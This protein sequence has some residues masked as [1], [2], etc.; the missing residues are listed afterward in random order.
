MKTI[1]PILLTFLVLI[2][3]TTF[4]QNK[5]V[6]AN[7]NI[8]TTT[9]TVSDFDKIAVSGSFDVTLKKGKGKA[10]TIEASS[11]LMDIIETIVE[12]NQLKIKF[13]S[14]WNIRTSKKINIT[15]TYEALSAVTLSGSGSIISED[16]I[17]ANNLALKVSGS[18]NMKLKLFTDN[19]TA[20]ISGSGNLKLTGETNIVTCS[21]SGSGNLN[22]SNL[23]AAITN[24]K[25][26]GSGNVKIQASEEIYAKASGS[27]NII[28]SGEPNIIKA[29]SSGSG[30]VRKI[31]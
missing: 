23:K 19:L 12:N 1:T 16:E 28:Y 15:V 13:K 22:A 27:G 2:T 21:L 24:A 30:S 26:S 25:V 6:K 8:I 9:R 18:G 7:G 29:N 11:N 31:N 4:S 3:T 5:K 10:V 17:I 14:G 20:T